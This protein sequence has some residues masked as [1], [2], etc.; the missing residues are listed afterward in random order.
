[1]YPGQI[2]FKLLPFCVVCNIQSFNLYEL[3]FSQMVDKGAAYARAALV[4]VILGLSG[5]I[6]E[7]LSMYKV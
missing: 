5:H 4:Y 6:D 1:M 2:S 3:V 7:S